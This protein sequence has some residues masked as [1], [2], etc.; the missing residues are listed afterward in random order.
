MSGA[1]SH[2]KSGNPLL[3]HP[4]LVATIFA[5]IILCGFVFAL[6]QVAVEAAEHRAHG[7]EHEGAAASASAS[8]SAGGEHK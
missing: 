8:A 3:D 6:Y 5:A 1:A 7:G 2:P 4:A